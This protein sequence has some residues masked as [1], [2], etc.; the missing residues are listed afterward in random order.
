M[1]SPCRQSM[2]PDS[3]VCPSLS[4]LARPTSSMEA[5]MSQ[6]VTCGED[7]GD[8]EEACRRRLFSFARSRKRKAIS[9]KDFAS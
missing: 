7:I 5:L 4:A 2:S 1:A 6:T 9:P 3:L 8:E